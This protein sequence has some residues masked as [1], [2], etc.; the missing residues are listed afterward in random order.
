MPS[1]YSSGPTTFVNVP[2]GRTEVD[3]L[4][5]DERWGSSA[6]SVTYLTYSFPWKNGVQAHFDADYSYDNEQWFGEGFN[7]TQQAAARAAVG[8]WSYVANIR[9]SENTETIQSVGEIRFGLSSADSISDSW[10]WAYLPSEDHPSA[11]DIWVNYE[12]GYESWAAG[13]YNYSSILHE[14]GH[15]LGLKH[16]HEDGVLMPSELDNSLYTV[17]SYEEAFDYVYPETPMVLD[18]LAIQYMYGTNYSHNSGNNT[19]TFSDSRPF[20]K[21]IWDGGGTDTVNIENFDGN[22]EIDLTPGSY[23]KLS[24]DGS[25]QFGI[26]Y[27]CIIENFIGG[28][29]SDRIR[30]NTSNNNLDGGGGS[31]TAVFIDSYADCTIS[32]SSDGYLITTKTSGSD[33]LKNIEYASFLDQ[34]I[35]LAT[36][37]GSSSG[38][39]SSGSSWSWLEVGETVIQQGAVS[40]YVSSSGTLYFLAA[41]GLEFGAD[42]VDPFVFK[43][44]N[45]KVL[46]FKT[47]P[48]NFFE[49]DDGIVSV[50]SMNLKGKWSEM[51]FDD[52]TGHMINAKIKHT[53]T[54]LLLAEADYNFDIN[55]DGLVGA[56]SGSV[57][58]KKFHV[59]NGFEEYR[60]DLGFSADTRRA[61]DDLHLMGQGDAG[62]LIWL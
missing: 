55:N 39:S 10:G 41:S 19:Y 12:F 44:G 43:K 57:I 56:S 27:N 16:P 53:T 32:A 15:A 6:S 21:T 30:G 17:M 11:G 51:M 26:A 60:G 38:S 8:E 47:A 7:Q 40:L 25:K 9:F 2:S 24:P 29:G 28:H 33:Y 46:T 35:S 13:S 58:Q 48:I 50:F 36:Y 14:I 18:I 5:T 54:S 59:V 34:T 31:D 61:Q 3:A 62:E 4:I 49:N 37:Q 1:P 42:N 22:T 20:L 23:S 52:E 45:G